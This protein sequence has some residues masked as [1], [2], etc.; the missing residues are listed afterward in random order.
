MKIAL[1]TASKLQRF[2]DVHF[3]LSEPYSSQHQKKLGNQSNKWSKSSC[4]NYRRPMDFM[5][6]KF[7]I[8]LK[9]KLLE[10]N[11]SLLKVY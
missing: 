5:G 8:E 6:S 4:C 10:I 3:S 7:Y 1:F 2:L 9:A 11:N